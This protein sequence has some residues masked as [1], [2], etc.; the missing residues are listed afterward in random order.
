M[1]STD[2]VVAA[3]CTV[4]AAFASSG[5][6]FITSCPDTPTGMPS[7]GSGNTAGNGSSG[8]SNTPGGGNSVLTGGFL[9]GEWVN[10][11]PDFSSVV[12]VCTPLYDM[13]S[14]P[15]E[16]LVTAGVSNHG[17][18]ATS[19]G[20]ES[21]RILGQ[22]DGSDEIVHSTTT[23]VYDPDHKKVFWVSGIYGDGLFRT[24]D[25][26]DTFKHLGDSRHDDYVTVDFSDKNRRTIILSGHENQLLRKSTD[27]GD[28]WSDITS[29]LPP[30]LKTCSFPLIIG[31]NQYLLGCGGGGSGSS[32]ILRSVDGGQ[33]WEQIYDNGGSAQPLLTTDGTIYWPEED[34]SGLAVSDDGG[35]SF[36]HVVSGV[37]RAV[38]PVELPGGRIASLANDAVVVSGDGGK[39]WKRASAALPYKPT[40]F[41]Y[42]PYQK[43]FFIWYF[44]CGSAPMAAPTDAIERFDYDYETQ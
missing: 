31:A 37:V 17:L 7:G 6:T 8:S 41:T 9:E 38:R 5:C 15:D 29:A 11:T 1:R 35:D 44:V 30:K 43:A 20:G 3:L 28:T 32:A 10:V 12:Q 27:G 33:S 23:I 2:G 42:S 14:K 16:D 34:G 4:V 18:W 22:G 26:G 25:D 21:W 19:D 13:S 40:G 36:S 39:T 24:D